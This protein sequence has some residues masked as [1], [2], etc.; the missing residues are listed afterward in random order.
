[1]KLL[2][3]NELQ[4]EGQWVKVGGNVVADDTARRIDELVSSELA[5]LATS[6]NGWDVL[7]III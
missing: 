2:E 3:P 4:L 5:K 6:E 1:M 7:Y